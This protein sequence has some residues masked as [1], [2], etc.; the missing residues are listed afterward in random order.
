[1][2]L[3]VVLAG[4]FGFGSALFGSVLW[5]KPIEMC[6]MNGVVSALGAAI[7]LRWWMRIW[8]HS[9]EQVSRENEMSAT[10]EQMQSG[11]E[12]GDSSNS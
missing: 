11:D 1:M 6:M 3:V 4:T 9:L 12:S 5:G 8:I 2:R 10:L 7:L